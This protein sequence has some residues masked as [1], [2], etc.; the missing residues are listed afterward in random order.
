MHTLGVGD[1]SVCAHQCESSSVC[2]HCITGDNRRPRDGRGKK[3]G[4]SE[5]VS[6][7]K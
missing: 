2:V 1:P 4:L 3:M 7:D 5:F 6:V